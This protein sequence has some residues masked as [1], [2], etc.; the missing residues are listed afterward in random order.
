MVRALAKMKSLRLAFPRSSWPEAKLRR[1]AKR[2]VKGLREGKCDGVYDRRGEK[3]KRS[4]FEHE[5]RG[6]SRTHRPL[7]SVTK[8]TVRT[9]NGIK[10]N[11]FPYWHCGLAS[12]CRS[13]G[14]SA[15]SCLA[16]RPPPHRAGPG[17]QAGRAADRQRSAGGPPVW[18]PS[19]VSQA[20]DQLRHPACRLSASWDTEPSAALILA[21]SGGAC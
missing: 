21:S 9:Y 10:D 15:N 3:R 18:L 7:L 14:L 16:S 8:K 20:G 11:F 13:V 2:Q 19:S 6:L 1:S 4:G 17:R 12:Q 5:L